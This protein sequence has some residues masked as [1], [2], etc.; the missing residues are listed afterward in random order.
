MRPRRP[1][2][3]RLYDTA[4]DGDLWPGTAAEIAA[5]APAP[6]LDLA[7][8]KVTATVAMEEKAWGTHAVLRL[9]NVTGPQKCSLIAVGKNGERET[10]TS[11]SVPTWGYGVPNAKTLSEQTGL[12][13][14]TAMRD[15]AWDIVKKQRGEA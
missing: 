7:A 4:L 11:W 1:P 9:N 5:T 8:T 15:V 6:Q 3:S 10:V 13:V 14:T 2:I 12:S